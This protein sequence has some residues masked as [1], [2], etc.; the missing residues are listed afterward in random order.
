M[1][2]ILDS[3]RSSSDYDND[4]VVV[5]SVE[6][7]KHLDGVFDALIIGS[8]AL[9]KMDVTALNE[10]KKC[11]SGFPKVVYVRKEEDTD[12]SLET[13]VRSVNGTI[14]D[15][16][17]Y[18]DSPQG[19][20]RL[21]SGENYNAVAVTDNIN[22][23]KEFSETFKG[24]KINRGQQLILS[25]A[26]QEVIR[27]EEENKRALS[28][29]T[30]AYLGVLTTAQESVEDIRKR[31]DDIKKKIVEIDKIVRNARNKESS[32]LVKTGGNVITIYP[33][34]ELEHIPSRMTIIIKDLGRTPYLTSFAVGF[35][36]YL[37]ATYARDTKVV[38]LEP[39]GYLYELKY[40]S[41]TSL[42]QLFVTQSNMRSTSDR[43]V[44][45]PIV[46]TNY[47]M[48]E[49]IRNIISRPNYTGL[50]LV[51]RLLTDVK[52]LIS[53]DG[54]RPVYAASSQGWFALRNRDLPWF[55]SCKSREDEGAMG[56]IPTFRDYDKLS[57]INREAAYAT[58]MVTKLYEDVI[59]LSGNDR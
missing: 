14:E 53:V 19:I 55:T 50:I 22:V 31:N 48:R 32:S 7:L 27:G 15:N 44:I 46:H 29:T 6:D 49:N 57:V 26:L 43:A 16:T 59:T 28:R 41:D 12:K 5:S 47:P 21:A 24:G 25:N 13:L 52:P 56:Y 35:A 23:L 2:V 38:F 33:N 1:I 9:G 20:K 18:L 40:P 51:D 36:Q 39:T 34:F 37:S 45:T 8:Y 30:G 4:A 58:P 17:D 11:L 10:F 42:K 3:G 54:V